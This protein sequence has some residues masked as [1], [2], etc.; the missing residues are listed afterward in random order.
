[1][2][3]KLV[4]ETY[5]QSK[6]ILAV[7]DSY[8]NIGVEIEQRSALAV[9]TNGRY[10]VRAGTIYPSND[11]NAIGVIFQDY[12]VTDGDAEAALTIF[13]FIKRFSLPAPPSS[14]AITALKQITFLPFAGQFAFALVAPTGLEFDGTVDTTFDVTIDAA[15]P[16]TDAALTPGN[17][18]LGG[19]AVGLSIAG[20]EIDGDGY[21]ATIHVTGTV[22]TGGTV[23][24]AAAAATNAANAAL[25]AVTVGSATV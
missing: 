2:A 7:P 25:A 18:T 15:V 3:K 11:A 4:K 14:A 13:G 6:T 1:M 16:F 12:D 19:T 21:T 17:W 23:T 5:G 8:V 9:Q 24:L 20:V 22:S 10:V